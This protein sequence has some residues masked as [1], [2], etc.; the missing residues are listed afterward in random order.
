[1]S[2]VC[3]DTQTQAA[4]ALCIHSLCTPTFPESNDR[5][6]HGWR[7]DVTLD[8]AHGS[9]VPGCAAA[10]CCRIILSQPCN[11]L[12]FNWRR[13][14]GKATAVGI[15]HHELELRWATV[16]CQLCKA[17]KPSQLATK[18]ANAFA[19]YS[20]C[21]EMAS[22][23]TSVLQALKRKSAHPLVDEYITLPYGCLGCGFFHGRT[24]ASRV[25]IRCS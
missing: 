10:T 3:L 18:D 17:V 25:V 9:W 21:R 7:D 8:F 6:R 20:H 23:G 11:F 22:G 1:M 19:S 14:A 15:A 4:H 5:S 12:Y 2:K 13:Y 24:V 16:K